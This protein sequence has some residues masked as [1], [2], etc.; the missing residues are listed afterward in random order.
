MNAD[1]YNPLP[2]TKLPSYSPTPLHQ[3]KVSER[4]FVFVIL[5]DDGN[6][7]EYLDSD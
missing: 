6:I 2:T 4:E 7:G 5:I 3:L 1:G